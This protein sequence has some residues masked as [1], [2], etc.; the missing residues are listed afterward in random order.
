M[1][2]EEVFAGRHRGVALLTDQRTLDHLDG[3]SHESHSSTWVNADRVKMMVSAVSTSVGLRLVA[4][5][6]LTPARLRV[7]FSSI[8]SCSGMTNSVRAPAPSWSK[9]AAR[10]RGL[11]DRRARY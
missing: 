11:C 7:D 5:M 9:K 3:R 4:R 6:V 10:V 1:T 8:R 2:P